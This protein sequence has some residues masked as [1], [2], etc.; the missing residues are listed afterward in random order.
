MRQ[1]QSALRYGSDKVHNRPQQHWTEWKDRRTGTTAIKLKLKLTAAKLTSSLVWSL[2]PWQALARD[3]EAYRSSGGMLCFVKDRPNHDSLTSSPSDGASVLVLVQAPSA[4]GDGGV[5]LGGWHL[6][7]APDAELRA[8]RAAQDSINN[9]GLDVGVTTAAELF[10]LVGE[11][12]LV[13]LVDAAAAA[14][15]VLDPEGV[16]HYLALFEDAIRELGL[17]QRAT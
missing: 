7:L 2:L 14:Q 13:H 3:K 1:M 10:E 6:A 16:V 8:H 17:A 9:R 5:G 11:E 15:A 4:E 12:S